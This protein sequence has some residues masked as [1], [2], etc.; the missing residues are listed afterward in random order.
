[1]SGGT[2]ISPDTGISPGVSYV[3]TVYNKAQFL[4]A[5]VAALLS[6]EGDFAREFIFVDDGSTDGSAELLAG[7]TRGVSDVTI[8]RQANG[9]PAAATNAGLARARLDYI[10]P[11]DGDDR[12][13]PPATRWLLEACTRTGAGV[14]FG[15]T[16]NGDAAPSEPADAAISL[17]ADPLGFLLRRAHFGPSA[18]LVRRD[19]FAAVCGCEESIF[20]QD[21]LMLLRLARRAA[22]VRVDGT[23]CLAPVDVPGRITENQAQILHDL[24]AAL[25]RFC[26]E[27][28]GLAWSVKR[29]ALRRAAFRAWHWAR[30]RAGAGIGSPSFWLAAASLLPA[31]WPGPWPYAPM[32]SATCAPFR[33]F[34]SIRV[35]I[36]KTRQ[37]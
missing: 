20:V 11:V 30:R 8:V 7:L 9:G 22:F 28:P 32:L 18:I 3:V 12:L 2:G 33:K 4:P 6:Q 37:S 10:K 26:A 34:A 29:T 19:L 15:E 13:P 27:T 35:P 14:A 5:T 17:L 24:N 36:G 23:V 16:V 25:A 31:L 21:Y 1:M